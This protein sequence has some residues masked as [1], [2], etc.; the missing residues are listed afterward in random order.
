LIA[1]LWLLPA[2]VAAGGNSPH[3]NYMLHCQGCHL[4]GGR[5]HPGIV[6]KMQGEIGQFLKSQAGR[7]YLVQVPGSAQSFLDDAQLA[8]VLNW[9]L[10]EFDP[11]RVAPDFQPYTAA[12][13]TRYRA[14]QLAD[15]GATRRA[16]LAG[17][18][19]D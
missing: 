15:V 13:V 19:G 18:L 1:A 7:A 3:V 17:E 9:M 2:V 8:E 6:P 11:K 16:L 12:E 5:G 10:R 4:E 14:T